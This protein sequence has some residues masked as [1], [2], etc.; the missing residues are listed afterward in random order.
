LRRNY[1]GFFL[2]SFQSLQDGERT[3][4]RGLVLSG[5]FKLRPFEP[6]IRIDGEAQLLQHRRCQVDA[7]GFYYFGRVLVDRNIL[8]PGPG[9]A[10]GN[11][12]VATCDVLIET[13]P[14]R[15]QSYDAGLADR[16]FEIAL[17]LELVAVKSSMAL[18]LNAAAMALHAASETSKYSSAPSRGNV[19]KSK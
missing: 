8:N 10:P 11:Q 19:A 2:I 14:Y 9:R 12:P 15:L 4:L 13:R 18:T 1:L 3:I 7:G 6:G 17:D 5:I 16:R